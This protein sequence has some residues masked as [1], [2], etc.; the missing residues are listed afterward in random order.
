MTQFQLKQQSLNLMLTY[1]SE[2]DSLYRDGL[3]GFIGIKLVEAESSTAGE[4]PPV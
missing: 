4:Q 1:A 3:D 2:Y